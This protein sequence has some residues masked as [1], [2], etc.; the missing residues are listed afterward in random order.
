MWQRYLKF[1]QAH[2]KKLREINNNKKTEN[3]PMSKESNYLWIFDPGHGGII[4]G[5]YQTSGKRS[6]KWEDG[7]QLFEGEFNR[8]VV[9]RLIKLCNDNGIDCI[10]LVDTEEDISLRKRTDKANDIWREQYDK[11]GKSCIYVSVHANGFSKESAHGWSVYTSEGETKSDRIAQVLAEKA[12]AE[13]P[14]SKMRRDTRDG[15]ADKEANFWVLRKTVMPAI[16][17]ENFFMTNRKESKFLLSEEG[18]DRI[19]KIHFQM[20]EEVESQKLV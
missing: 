16:L 19:A 14:D 2:L 3:K 8:A 17:S 4:D 7:T 13:F 11:G 20:I 18:R 10:N 6:P 9:K 1:L 12:A 5:V 15:D